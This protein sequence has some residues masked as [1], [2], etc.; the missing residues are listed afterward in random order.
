MI[1]VVVDGPG[2]VAL[3]FRLLRRIDAARIAV[4]GEFN[5]WDRAATLME[6]VGDE[7]SA[8][9]ALPAGRRY[10]FRYLIDDQR[11]EN[12]WEADD[13]T[14]NEFGGSDSVVD[15]TAERLQRRRGAHIDPSS[16]S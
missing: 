14:D 16:L 2:S 11:W 12:D 9:V 4:V 7:W 3:T 15:L 13:Y 6:L 1:D 8:T 10:R 5:E